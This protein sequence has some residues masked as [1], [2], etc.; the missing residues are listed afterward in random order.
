M[1][2]VIIVIMSLI[3]M[4]WCLCRMR[5]HGNISDI[6]NEH[7][8]AFA[9]SLPISIGLDFPKGA[10]LGKVPARESKT[11]GAGDAFDSAQ[12]FKMPKTTVCGGGFF[13]PG[14]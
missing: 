14:R 4:K 2:T 8:T 11:R 9:A 5:K 7:I 13:A 10:A 3:D 12:N 6:E 1:H